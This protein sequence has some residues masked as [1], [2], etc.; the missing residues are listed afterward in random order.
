MKKKHI[1]LGIG[2]AIGGVI[3]WK[4]ASRPSTVNFEDVADRVVHAEHSNFVEVD[5]AE[6]H[7]QEFGDRSKPTMLLVHG[8][9]ASVY[10]WKTVAPKLADAGF[11]VVALDLIGF[12]YSEKPAWFDYSIQS[13][14]RMIS[15]F[16]DRLGIGTATL[17]G[18]SYG[19]AVVLTVALDYPERVEKLVLVDAVINDEPKNHPILKLASVPGIGEVMTPFLLDSKTFI[20]LRMQNTLAP[21]NH[22]LIT[23]D[24]VES[25]IRPLAAAD[26]HRAVLRT[27]RNW[28]ADR[29]EHDLGLINQPT[30]IVWGEDDIVIP[31][32]NAETLY[33]SIVHSRLVVLKNCGHVPQEEKPE[34]FT[35]L[36]NE[37][38]HDRKGR[39]AAGDGDMQVRH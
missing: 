21:V 39:I 32:R 37:F 29:I 34:I 11:H 15:R 38:A 3:A 14:A 25:I 7:F 27:G 18:S 31:I 6:V 26:G 24:R 33:N 30:L 1:A 8:F 5:G 12:G 13:Q 16:M 2:G 10:V 20:K 23:R 22:H 35:N 19:G 9:T 4:L 17:V 36:V 28:N